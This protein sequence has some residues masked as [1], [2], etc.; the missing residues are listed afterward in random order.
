M[1][2][3]AGVIFNSLFIY[4]YNHASF[5]TTFLTMGQANR[6]SGSN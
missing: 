1:I 6:F 5:S 4:D 3:A 2:A